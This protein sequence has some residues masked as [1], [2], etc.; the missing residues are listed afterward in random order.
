MD[1]AMEV[2]DKLGATVDEIALPSVG[3]PIDEIYAKVRGIEAYTYHSQWIAESTEKYQA[4]TRQRI[5]QNSAGISASAYAQ[6]HLQLQLLRREI[7]KVFAKVDL[8]ITPTLPS[9][10]VLISQGADAAAVSLR[11]TSPFDVLG[12][13]AISIPCGFTTSGLPFGLQIAGAPF[14]ELTVLA[15]AHSYEQETEWHNRHPKLRP[16]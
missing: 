5:M 2:L 6:A 14:A 10:P 3:M 13:P 12:L 11:N 15:L 4:T 8:L 16:V 7:K 1:A 9:P